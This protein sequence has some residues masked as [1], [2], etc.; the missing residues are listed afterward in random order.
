MSGPVSVLSLFIDL[1]RRVKR[2]RDGVKR[3]IKKTRTTRHNCRNIELYSTWRLK[4]NVGTK[5]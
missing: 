3:R 1:C 4:R 2:D 5:V